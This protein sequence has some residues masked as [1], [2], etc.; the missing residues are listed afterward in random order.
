MIEPEGYA[1]APELYDAFGTRG[2][3]DHG[4]PNVVYDPARGARKGAGPPL[5]RRSPGSSSVSRTPRPGSTTRTR[6]RASA[7]T[8][9]SG[10]PTF[11]RGGRRL[12][13]SGVILYPID[14]AGTPT[15]VQELTRSY[16]DFRVLDSMTEPGEPDRGVP[17]LPHPGPRRR[18][19]CGGMGR[20]G[21]RPRGG[22]RLRDPLPRPVR[23]GLRGTQRV[24]LREGRLLARRPAPAAS[25][26]GPRRAPR[27]GPLPRPPPL[28]PVHGRLL[29]ALLVLRAAVD[30]RPGREP[31]RARTA[32]SCSSR[33]CSPVSSGCR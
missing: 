16:D 33:A 17:R 28:P 21:V 30:P 22:P 12:V 13:G 5:R 26:V 6:R 1:S 3:P 15:H 18:G 7:R 32:R 24:R 2:G 10:S 9:S 4:R 19:G 31:V 27:S 14:W 23:L 11:V 25:S 20:A 8:P 29:R